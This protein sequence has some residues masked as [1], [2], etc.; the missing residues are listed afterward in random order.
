M[1]YASY[2]SFYYSLIPPN[3][4]DD[5]YANQQLVH[6]EEG[7]DEA[8][9][10]KNGRCAR[11]SHAGYGFGWLRHDVLGR[12][13]VDDDVRGLIDLPADPEATSIPER[14]NLLRLFDEEHFCIHFY[15]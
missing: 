14:S 7:V 10:L 3:F 6:E 4:A 12:L 15:F 5:L 13:L 1:N 8:T 2:F 9:Y 11:D